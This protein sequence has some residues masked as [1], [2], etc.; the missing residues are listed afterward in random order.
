MSNDY[1]QTYTCPTCKQRASG[2]GHI[3]HPFQGDSPYEC[4]FCKQTVSEA[5][6]ICTAMLDKI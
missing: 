2:R 3:C 1:V 5:R 4:E 6:H